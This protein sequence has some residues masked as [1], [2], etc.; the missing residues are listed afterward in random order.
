MK[1]ILLIDCIGIGAYQALGAW[2]E[3][4]AK[5]AAQAF[6]ASEPANRPPSPSGFKAMMIPDGVDPNVV[7]VMT[8]EQCPAEWG[9]RGRGLVARLKEANIPVA[10]T[11]SLNISTNSRTREERDNL[12]A[13]GQGL[14]RGELPIVFYRGRAKN[15]PAFGDVLAEYQAQ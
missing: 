11:G 14:Q 8:P 7:T 5:A 2:R 10:V 12:I 3:H 9:K 13:L 1:K 6:L 15:N 4:K